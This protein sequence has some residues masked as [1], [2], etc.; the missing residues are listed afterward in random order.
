MLLPFF[1]GQEVSYTLVSNF[2]TTI[3]EY[4]LENLEQIE[5]IVEGLSAIFEN[6]DYWVK[7]LKG[8]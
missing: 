7:M 2:I 8:D 4:F 5:G 3:K 1:K 6:E